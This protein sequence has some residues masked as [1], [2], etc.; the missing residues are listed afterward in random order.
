M[1]GLVENPIKKTLRKSIQIFKVSLQI[2]ISN[3]FNL[4][5]GLGRESSSEKHLEKMHSN[6]QNKP[7]VRHFNSIQTKCWP[8]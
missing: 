1:L 7:T 6:I 8:W 4:S 2:G 5:V 3:Q